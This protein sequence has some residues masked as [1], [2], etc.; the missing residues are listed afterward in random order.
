MKKMAISRFYDNMQKLQDMSNFSWR[1]SLIVV[2][3]TFISCTVAPLT[4]DLIFFYL[5]APGTTIDAKK[6]NIRV[7]VFFYCKGFWFKSAA[8]MSHFPN[9]RALSLKMGNFKIL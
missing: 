2:M 8:A 6:G 1:E 4:D 3:V 7:R 9:L 5:T